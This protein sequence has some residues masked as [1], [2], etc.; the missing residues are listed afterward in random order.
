MY[1]IGNMVKTITEFVRLGLTLDLRKRIRAEARRRETS[2]SALMRA[3]L[4]QYLSEPNPPRTAKPP[5]DTPAPT[6]TEA[7]QQYAHKVLM[8]HFAEDRNETIRFGEDRSSALRRPE[9]LQPKN[10]KAPN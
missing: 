1:K 2:L 4:E 5:V 7:E 10:T 6:W 8:D 9:L 3:A